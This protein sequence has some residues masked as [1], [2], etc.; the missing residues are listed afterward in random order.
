L[1]EKQIDSHIK[2]EEQKND[3]K[4]KE[5][6]NLKKKSNIKLPTYLDEPV[7]ENNA[8]ELWEDFLDTISGDSDIQKTIKRE[9]NAFSLSIVNFVTC[10]EAKE[11][12]EI[13]I[14]CFDI[15]TKLLN[16]LE[17]WK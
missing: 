17:F 12:K 9:E 5:K 11:E 14:N 10:Y 6:T 3:F 7:G 4:K 2:I 8:E 16:Y 15:L 13:M 1:L